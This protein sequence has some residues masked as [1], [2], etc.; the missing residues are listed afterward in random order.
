VTYEE[1][2]LLPSS[3][4]ISLVTCE[5]VKPV[6][7]FTLYSGTTYKKH[8]P[9]F[10]KTVK[11]SGIELTEGYDEDSLDVGDY[12][13]DAVYK[14]LYVNVGQD[15]KFESLSLVYKFF[16][17]NTPLILPNDLV[18][19]E[20]VEWLPYIQNIGSIGQQLDD[21]NTGIVL[22]S[23]S[24]VEL[25]NNGRFFD[26][27][28]DSLIFENQSIVF[29][30]WFNNLSRAEI[31]KIFEGVIE[32]KDF[33][34]NKVTFRVK[35]YVFRLKNQVNLGLFSESDG[36]VL[37]SVLGTPKRR[38]YGQV[39]QAKCVPIDCVLNG[40]ALTGTVSLTLNSTTLTGIGTQFLKELNQDDEL[41]FSIQGEEVLYSVDLIASNTSLTL[42]KK[43]EQTLINQSVLVDPKHKY[44]FK[45]RRW[46]I[47]GHKIRQTE[48]M[49]V[50]VINAR[51][52]VIDDVSEFVSGDVVRVNNQTTQVTRISSNQIILEQNI[53]PIPVVGNIIERFPVTKLHYGERELIPFRDFTLTNTT[54]AIIELDP[55]AEF[56]IA[57]E[58]VTDHNLSFRDGRYDVSSSANADLRTIIKPG[59]FIRPTTQ[60]NENWYEVHHVGPQIVWLKTIF[61]N[62]GSNSNHHA[63][64]KSVDT[65]SDD[66]LIT[67]DCY[68]KDTDS[69][70]MR[71]ASDCVKDLV[72]NDAGFTAI[73][74]SSFIQ[75]KDDCKYTLSMVIPDN[76]GDEAPTI[77][78]VISNINQSVFGS[79]YG[80]SSQEIAYSIVNTRRPPTMAALRDDDILSWEVQTNQKIV[81]NVKV[82]Y[83]PFVDKVTG[84]NGFSV[85]VY[86][87]SFVDQNIGIQNTIEKTCYLFNDSDA[88]TIAQRIAFYYSLSQSILTLKAKANFFTSSVNDRVYIDLDR[89]YARY[90]GKSTMKI[91]VISGVKKSAYNSEIIMNDLGNIFNRC[92]AI[93]PNDT[94]SFTNSSDDEKIK[95]GYILDPD[96]LIPGNDEE[97]LG[98]GLIG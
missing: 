88:E 51:T 46:H 23:Q 30:S 42:T 9:Y 19:G 63:R 36:D 12:Y 20:D 52:F 31:K 4:K 87:N 22:E 45:N 25:I 60:N 82:N 54:E 26:S 50:T 83:S 90:G 44:R 15:P 55:L 29:Y 84:E 6:K 10:V 89:L 80:N 70:W 95:F 53:F 68:G 11:N 69:T 41:I 1:A 67:V 85:I 33:S 21:E 91:G 57:R 28:I 7:L 14:T 76:I 79:L 61:S 49:I 43:A 8:V 18:N 74:T 75:A 66:S 59:D 47:A 86:Q 48:A 78:D 73:D 97:D 71:T 16:F 58:L 98:S 93:A 94:D 38:I 64:I 65:V 13:F 92:P 72:V 3:E 34:P 32:S 17:S 37:E 62:N 56:N 81:N 5:A 96:T 2:S 35:D 39:K 27:I 77:R 40:Y 24:S